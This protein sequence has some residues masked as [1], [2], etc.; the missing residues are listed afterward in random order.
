MNSYTVAGYDIALAGYWVTLLGFLASFASLVAA[1]LAWHAAGGARKA[2][3]E[4]R[5]SLRRGDAKQSMA[6]ITSDCLALIDALSGSNDG[7]SR[8]ILLRLEHDIEYW[9]TRYE[10]GDLGRRGLENLQAVRDGVR[11]ALDTYF[12][13]APRSRVERNGLVG[14][15]LSPLLANVACLKATV[16]SVF[17]KA[18]RR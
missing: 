9:A 6:E 7:L 15:I 14:S 16:D 18:E 8:H 5:S 17:D 1:G 11:S 13:E 4:T 10:S 3:E 12:A 2:A